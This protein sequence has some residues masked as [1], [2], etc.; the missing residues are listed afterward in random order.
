MWVCPHIICFFISQTKKNARFL[1]FVYLSDIEISAGRKPSEAGGA[2]EET[3]GR[4]KPIKE[5]AREAVLA[6]LHEERGNKDAAAERLGVSRSTL[7]N[8]IKKYGIEPDPQSDPS[9][10]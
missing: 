8:W 9:R 7:F 2:K 4:V 5:Y 3:G 1:D 6:A 10:P